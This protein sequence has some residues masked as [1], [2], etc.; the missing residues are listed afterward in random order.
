MLLAMGRDQKILDALGE[1]AENLDL[2]R[3]ASRDPK[4]AARDHGIEIPDN[5]ML[6]LEVDGD[7]VSLRTTYYD[8]LY[9]VVVTW[10]N[11]A[12][13]SDPAPRRQT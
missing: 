4:S 5:V 9:P 7:Q 11:R 12:G 10:D 1:L 6:N 3:K 8:D 13:F 2:A